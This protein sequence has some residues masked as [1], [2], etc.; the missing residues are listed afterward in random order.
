MAI[1]NFIEQVCKGETREST[2]S[3]TKWENWNKTSR[4]TVL[5]LLSRDFEE[6]PEK[7]PARLKEILKLSSASTVVDLFLRSKA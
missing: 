1:L 3:R 6:E 2:K 4:K 7:I 5:A